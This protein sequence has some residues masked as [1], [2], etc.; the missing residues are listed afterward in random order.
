MTITKIN[1]ANGLRWPNRCAYCNEAATKSART[2]F[3]V[4][5]GFFLVAIRETTHTVTFPVCKRHRWPAKF[6]G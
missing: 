3:R 2:H 1:L 5:D 4:I 6:Y